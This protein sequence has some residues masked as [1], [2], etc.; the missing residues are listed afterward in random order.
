MKNVQSSIYKKVYQEHCKITIP[1][2]FDIH[3]LDGNRENNKIEN[4]LMLPQKLHLD[5]HDLVSK[6]HVINFNPNINSVNETGCRV[7]E[8]AFTFASEFMDIYD[9]C[10]VW[11]DYKEFLLGNLPNIHNI[12]ISK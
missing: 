6:I 8:M 2:N 9:K 12:E 11:K 3:H 1:K 4:L 7:N 10:C 5:Y